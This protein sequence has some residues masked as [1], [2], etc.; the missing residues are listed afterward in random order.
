MS[1]NYRAGAPRRSGS[2]VKSS[3]GASPVMALS[4][5]ASFMGTTFGLSWSQT[6]LALSGSRPRSG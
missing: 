3:D 4:W 5:S 1:S 2:R 6:K